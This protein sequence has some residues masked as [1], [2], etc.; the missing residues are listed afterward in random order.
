MEMETS[1]DAQQ[2][3]LRRGYLLDNIDLFLRESK[4]HRT[5]DDVEDI[6]GVTVWRWDETEGE[7][8]GP[9]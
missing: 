2:R 3:F 9:I 5:H 1:L 4:Y 7:S 8:E 6:E